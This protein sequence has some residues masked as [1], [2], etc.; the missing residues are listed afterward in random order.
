MNI[1][2][3]KNIVYKKGGSQSILV[4]FWVEIS[5]ISKISSKIID[6]MMFLSDLR[7]N[8]V[9][10]SDKNSRKRFIHV[11]QY[12]RTILRSAKSFIVQILLPHFPVQTQIR[13]LHAIRYFRYTHTYTLV[14]PTKHVSFIPI[15]IQYLS[16]HS[17]AFQNN[18]P[19][20]AK[21]HSAI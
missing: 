20:I 15:P 4:L 19:F 1:I 5:F 8:N 17:F 7:C 12:L 10:F 6:V 16:F 11:Q 18:R 14:Q 3:M 2:Y 9:P 21:F 13:L